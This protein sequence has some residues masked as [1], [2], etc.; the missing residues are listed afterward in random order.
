MISDYFKL[1]KKYSIESYS[2]CGED[3][4]IDF[5][6]KAC[7]L[8]IRNYFDIGANHPYCGSNTFKFYQQGACGVCVEPIPQMARKFTKKRPR[9]IIINK[10]IAGI[11][12]SLRFYVIDPSTLSTFD[13]AAR[14]R[15]LQTPG[16][17]LVETIEVDALTLDQ[18]FKDY[19]TPDLLCIDVEGG[20]LQL[21]S[22]WSTTKYRPSILCVEDL[23]YSHERKEKVSVGVTDYLTNQGYMLFADTFINRIFVDKKI[24]TST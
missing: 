2:Q 20:D 23:E 8:T 11:E 18:L 10:A 24:W 15:A 14:D 4:I 16:A 9:D 17:S 21:I 12:K 19:G 5:V 6:A 13:E 7:N 3:I 1:Y 22:S